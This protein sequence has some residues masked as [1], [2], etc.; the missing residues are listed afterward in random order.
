MEHF[1][2]HDQIIVFHIDDDEYQLQFTKMFLESENPRLKV[3]SFGTFDEL[4]DRIGDRHDCVLSDF[5]MPQHNGIEICEIVKTIEEIPFILYTGHG[6]EEVA[7]KAF[8]TGVDDYLRKELKPSHYQVLARRIVQAVEKYR[9]DRIRVTYKNRLEV[10]HKY[11]YEIAAASS[12]KEIAEKTFEAI[13]NTLEFYFGG[14]HIVEGN[15]LVEKFS[16]CPDRFEPMD[17]SLD[18]S[19]VMV[20]AFKQG[21][22]QIVPDTRLDEDYTP[23]VYHEDLLS[24]VAVPVIIDNKV[25]GMVNVESKLLN[26]FSDE[27]VRLLETLTSH[28]ASSY[29]RL[30]KV[31]SL[32]DSERKIKELLDSS[33]EAAFMLSGTKIVYVNQKGIE[34]LGYHNKEDLIGKIGFEIVSSTYRERIMSIISRLQKREEIG[35]RYQIPLLRK[36]GSTILVETHLNIIEYEGK[37]AL[38][39][40]IRDISEKESY[41]QKFT[42]LYESSV[43]I[44]KAT[45]RNEICSVVLEAIESI[46]GFDYGSI[47]LVEGDNLRFVQT[48]GFI[49]KG[50]FLRPLTSKSIS[51]RCIRTGE[52]QIVPDISK[53]P[54][55]FVPSVDIETGKKIKS[56]LVVPIKDGAVVLGV[57]NVESMKDF[58]FQD[59][60]IKLIETLAM[61]SAT[62]LS[63]IEEKKNIDKII[64]SKTKQILQADRFASLGKVTSMVAHD[65]RNPLQTI[66]NAAFFI[67]EDE[68][69]NVNKIIQAVKYADQIIEDIK[70]NTV[71]TP[72]YRENTNI[73][74][75]VNGAVEQ[76]RIPGNIEFQIQVSE[77]LTTV[78]IDPVKIKRIVV[79]LI[80][81]SIEAMPEGGRIALSVN[82]SK[83][84]LEIEVK[85]NGIGI[86][87]EVQDVLFSKMVTTKPNGTGLGLPF[88]KRAAEKHG[89][90]IDIESVTGKGTS[91]RVFIPLWTPSDSDD[92]IV[93]F[94]S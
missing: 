60:E 28:I 85:D 58:P 71:D 7:Q 34:L 47:G 91:V 87:M 48:L 81:N 5:Q 62:A 19:G 90:S 49:S 53:D 8:E 93:E 86:P 92:S 82:R 73:H 26:A 84:G 43:Q 36:D 74:D 25:E 30:C 78:N 2:T 46:L 37:P 32:V 1:D 89:G 44:F 4:I 22:T 21:K 80:N 42:K 9:L 66:R 61:Y 10:L 79:N 24:E 23:W 29:S 18:G 72:L 40:F 41:E 3:V 17:L 15:M 12:L 14:I 33:M 55:Y 94:I 39:S 38:L 45:T 35:R 88:C 13:Q 83:G 69:G 6:S 50:D 76:V 67:K 59:Y 27:D 70:S 20:R 75:V 11:T 63:R 68:T 54:D 52:I 65:I 31:Q 51:T 64:E 57:I 56:E 16:M 77:E